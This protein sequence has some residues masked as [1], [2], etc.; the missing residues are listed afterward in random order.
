FSGY[1][2]WLFSV[3]SLLFF[4][5]FFLKQGLTLSLRLK[6]SGVIISHRSLNLQGSGNP[7]TSAPRVAET[8][9]TCHHTQLIFKFFHR[10]EV[11]LCCPSWCQTSGLKRSSR[12]SLTKC[13]DYRHAPPHLANFCIY[14]FLRWSFALVTQARVQWGDL[15]SLLPPPPSFK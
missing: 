4:F 1:H 15:S 12:L 3:E 10:N 11:S 8:T 13:W 5:F 7:S 2:Y 6:C 9:G 14:L